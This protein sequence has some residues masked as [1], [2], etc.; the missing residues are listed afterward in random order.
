MAG[1]R[2]RLDT[3]QLDDRGKRAHAMLTALTDEDGL[4]EWE[5]DFVA[6]LSEWFYDKQRSLSPKQYDRLKSI[7]E[8]FN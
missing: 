5:R 2:D 8:R 3:A 7:Y 4:T 1:Q 6:S